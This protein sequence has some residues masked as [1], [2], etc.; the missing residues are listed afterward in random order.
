MTKSPDQPPA[1]SQPSHTPTQQANISSN[2]FDTDGLNLIDKFLPVKSTP[3]QPLMAKDSA[4]S[5]DAGLVV[6]GYT[7]TRL[8]AQGG[9][10]KVWHGYELTLNREVAM[11]TLKPGANA[12]RF[13][14]EAKITA[15]LPHPNIPPVYAIG[16]LDNGTPWLAMKFVRGHTLNTLLQTTPRSPASLSQMVQIFEQVAQAVGFAHSHGLIHRDIKPPNIMV[17]EFGEVLLMDWG[18]AKNIL[19]STDPTEPDTIND[20]ACCVNS[21]AESAGLTEEGH[22]LGTPG[23]MA[24]EQAR[25]ERLDARTDVFAL[26]SL[27]AT[28]LTGQPAFV[29]ITATD[30]LIRTAHADLADV[31]RRLDLCGADSE[32]IAVAKRCLSAIPEGRPAD[33]REVAAMVATYRANVEARLRHAET[34]A[35]EALVLAAEASKR[36]RL[37]IWASSAVMLSLGLGLVVSLTFLQRAITAENQAITEAQRA[38]ESETTAIAERDAKDLAFQDRT[39]ALE[40]EQQ[41][42]SAERIARDKTRTALRALTD[43]LV[44]NQLSREGFLTDDSK[45]FLRMMIE[46]YQQLARL[47]GD[48][49]ESRSIQGEGLFRVGRMQHHLGEFV[50]A[51]QT[52]RKAIELYQK[53]VDDF[54]DQIDNQLDLASCHHNFGL[55]LFEQGRYASAE[56]SQRAAL[57][58]RKRLNENSPEQAQLLSDLSISYNNL[59]VLL[60]QTGRLDEADAT[61]DASLAI[62]KRLVEKYPAN[63]E[64]RFRLAMMYN[65]MGNRLNETH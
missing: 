6:P 5:I 13:I 38:L 7:V 57:T 61:R 65:N 39:K 55:L 30:I 48:D 33:G 28:I 63:F 54:P 31:K 17:G 11:K 53:L 49:A 37:R 10:G 25:G 43:M 29:G 36:R 62:Q 34:R 45:A 35:A 32:L 52:Y 50:A 56:Q 9:M 22:V 18:L 15:M 59:S 3:Q 16:Q 12:D 42:R 60:R 64:Y 27:L 23:Y 2:I 26:G 19:H 21:I 41:A 58:I 14:T 8:I 24:P 44:E 1:D 46:Q 47:S 4:E 51:E 40:S 20:S